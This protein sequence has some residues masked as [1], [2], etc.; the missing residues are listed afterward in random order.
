MI[1]VKG[2]VRPYSLWIVCAIANQAQLENRRVL[3][4]AGNDSKHKVGSLHYVDKAIDFRTKDFESSAA[5]RAFLA[6]V[7]SRLG[8]GFEG[9]IEFEGRDNEH[10]HIETAPTSSRPASLTV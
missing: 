2:T 4:S 7:L 10:G 9:W 3:V 5:K 8:A 6:A 1:F